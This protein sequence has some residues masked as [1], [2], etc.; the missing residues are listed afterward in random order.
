LPSK[1]STQGA[2]LS[3]AP[4]SAIWKSPLLDDFGLVTPFAMRNYRAP[5]AHPF[6]HRWSPIFLSILR[7]V[8]GLLFMEHG[9]QKLFNFPPSPQPNEG[10]MQPLMVVGAWMEFA[11]GLL[12]FLGLF[13]RPVAFLLS[14]E[15]AVA[16]FMFHANNSLYP[17]LNRGE[18]AVIYCFIFLFLAIAGPG[19]WSIDAMWKKD[20]AT[21]NP[22]TT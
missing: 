19:P 20:A 13:T 3:E 16:Y 17:I 21:A 22:V 2:A 9:S 8:I 18:A 11:G 7:I 4:T 6:F 12:V 14:G 10:P 5:M 15:M 1:S